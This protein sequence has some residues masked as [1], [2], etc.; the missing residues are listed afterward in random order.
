MG[1]HK[2]FV[3]AKGSYA[4]DSEGIKYLD[5]LC[6]FGA[7][8]L[9]HNHPRVL[10]ALRK[11]DELPNLLQFSLGIMAGGL[12]RNLALITP[13]DLRRSFFCNSG[14][15]AVEGA[16]KLARAA[17]E[18]HRIASTENSYHGKT[19]GALSVTGRKKYQEPFLPLLPGVDHVPYGDAAVLEKSLQSR[20]AA[21]FIVEP[22][23]GEGGVIVPLSG[24][25]SEVRRLCS[26][27]G[28]LLIIDEIQTGFGRTGKMFACE[29]EEVTPD[30]MCLAKVLGGGVM[31]IG[32]FITT[33][34]IWDKAFGGIAKCYRH[35]STVGGNSRACAAGIAAIQVIVSEKLSEA[36]AE[37]GAYLMRKIVALNDKYQVI[38]EVRGKGL[39]LGVEFTEVSG[40]LLKAVSSRV[41]H[42]LSKENFAALVAGELLNKHK[43][44][45]GCTLSNPNLIRLAPPLNINYDEIGYFLSALDEVL[46]RFKSYMGGNA[47]KS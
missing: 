42:A 9:G 16:L 41:V 7:I 34:E 5:L 33:D 11:A 43:I 23:Q 3:T 26:K 20:D 2:K 31:P 40:D 44:F 30:V 1:P 32:A 46:G 19:M 18:N 47:S 6:S 28:A 12:A 22:I 17:F 36:A 29:H 8:G 39:L 21:A 37:K 14:T 15:E 27:Y 10:D 35:S 24:Y 13:G 4:W 25:L 38:K 45:T